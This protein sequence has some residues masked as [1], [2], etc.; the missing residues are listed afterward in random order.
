MRNVT[1]LLS[2]MVVT[3]A[4]AAMEPAA[5]VKKMPA[6]PQLQKIDG[7][8]YYG[9]QPE[10]KLTISEQAEK[11]FQFNQKATKVV[12]NR[13]PYAKEVWENPAYEW[14]I[15]SVIGKGQEGNNTVR[16]TFEFDKNGNALQQKNYN[17]DASAN[18]WMLQN[19]QT[20]SW[21]EA[22]ACAS[23]KIEFFFGLGQFRAEY[24]LSLWLR[25]ALSRRL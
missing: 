1:L 19:S 18:D 3:P 2:L 9:N 22:N 16:Q 13:A 5:I 11:G 10:S 24:N 23:D 14:K 4:I 7:V 25:P 21:N 20:M 8:Y 17:W 12:K 6:A 15:D